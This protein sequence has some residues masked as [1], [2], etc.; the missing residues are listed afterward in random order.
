MS[1]FDPKSVAQAI[2]E[3]RRG[4]AV[5]S[6]SQ[7]WRAKPGQLSAAQIL[8]TRDALASGLKPFR[9]GIARSFT[10]EPVVP[11]LRARAILEGIDLAVTL[12]AFNN[13]GAEMLDAASILLEPP[14][15]AVLLA[16][17][18]RDVAPRLWADYPGADVDAT[19]ELVDQAVE[20]YKE[21]IKGMRRMSPVPLIVQGLE[22]PLHLT[23]GV[24]DGRLA[25][26]Q[27]AAISLVNRRL[28]EFAALQTG[29]YFLDMDA[30]VAG[31]GRR[32]WYDDHKWLTARA[33]IA[34]PAQPTFAEAILRLVVPLCRG[35]AKVLALDLDNTV[36]GGVVGEDGI[37]GLD[38][39]TEHPGAGYRALQQTALDLRKRGAL[40]V[41]CSKNNEADAF[42][43][44]DKHPGMLLRREHVAAHR[45]NWNNKADNLRSLAKELNLGLESFVF[46]DDNPTERALVRRE[47]PD[48]RVLELP[49]DPVRY[50]E[51]LANV[52]WFEQ[53]SLTG[54]DAA[55][56]E[57]YAQERDR[58]VA[59]GEV[60]NLEKF[61]ETL[62]VWVSVAAV[63]AGSVARAA[64]LTQKTNQFNLT[65]RRYQESMLAERAAS[66]NWGVYVLK[67]G[68]RFGDN[69]IVCVG[70]V[71][72]AGDIAEIDS[73]LMSCRV[74]GRGVETAFLAS[75]IQLS[76][77]RGG[78]RM[79]GWFLPT[80]KNAPAAEF[81]AQH[82]FVA[83]ERDAQ[84]STLWERDI[85]A[86]SPVAAPAWIRFAP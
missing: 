44:L 45:I 72:F 30:L 38:V 82:G 11:I 28:C 21:L 50:A 12:G 41:L 16:L 2:V 26:G 40:I 59:L 15:D 65:T 39:G 46:V 7:L 24:F 56:T 19:Q 63:D 3:N 70:I 77:A 4:D 58:Q 80:A 32:S 5:H 14:P 67:S 42:E 29:V 17:Q 73:F 52:L 23:F 74:I 81:Y 86:A 75:L 79:R 66:A 25:L 51:A 62:G 76:I 54:E 85:S 37:A 68:D 84:G 60:G 8:S 31:F 64:Q 43:A 35:T 47:L 83:V 1:P 48:V 20:F 18:T 71:D 27:S 49:E 33:P 6:L 55:R 69:G 78:K 57:L 61:L 53:L 22:T 13:F 34:A 9:L 10:I 36:W